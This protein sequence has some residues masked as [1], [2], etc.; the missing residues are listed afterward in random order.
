MR[1][2]Y[3]HQSVMSLVSVSLREWARTNSLADLLCHLVG[4]MQTVNMD[5]TPLI[6]AREN[7]LDLHNTGGICFL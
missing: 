7:G 3:I 2:V 6:V 4:D 1:V 5:C